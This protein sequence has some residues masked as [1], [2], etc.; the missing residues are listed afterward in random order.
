[1][2]NVYFIKRGLFHGL[3]HA[4][5]LLIGKLIFKL[6]MNRHCSDINLHFPRGNGMDG[7]F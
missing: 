2:M 7:L 6:S 5:S 4:K 1:M 3:K